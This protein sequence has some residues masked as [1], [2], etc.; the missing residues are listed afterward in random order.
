MQTHCSVKMDHFT[1]AQ[2]IHRAH[3]QYKNKIACFGAHL[4]ATVPLV[5]N[6]NQ[7][8]QFRDGS[9]VFIPSAEH[10]FIKLNFWFMC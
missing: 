7:C 10:T 5:K 8:T 4:N 9:Q 1:L 2:D 3:F 6:P